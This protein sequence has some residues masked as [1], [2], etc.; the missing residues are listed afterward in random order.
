MLRYTTI[1]HELRKKWGLTYSEYLVCDS[2]H[3]LSAKFPCRAD[4]DYIAGFLEISRSTYFAAKKRLVSLGL[5]EIKDDGVQTTERWWRDVT[6]TQTDG[7]VDLNDKSVK[8]VRKSDSGV[9][10]SD[11]YIYNN[12]INISEQSSR[13][14]DEDLDDDITVVTDEDLVPSR[15]FGKRPPSLEPKIKKLWAFWPGKHPEWQINKTQRKS[16]EN[17]IKHRDS[18]QV[19][20]ALQFWLDNRDDPYCPDVST[21]YDLDQKWDKLLSYRD[22]KH[23][24]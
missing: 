11:S 22:K 16:S 21:P 10:K 13:E 24:H 20:K 4:A 12:N 15:G 3:Q 23:G 8:A 9:R 2:I 6:F 14:N 17:I 5:V 1:H 18:I 19:Q 7:E